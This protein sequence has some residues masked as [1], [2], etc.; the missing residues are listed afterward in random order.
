LALAVAPLPS[1][2]QPETATRTARSPIEQ[3]MVTSANEED[4]CFSDRAVRSCL[5]LLTRA[6]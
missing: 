4:T 2:L 6:P 1:G 3:R 5:R